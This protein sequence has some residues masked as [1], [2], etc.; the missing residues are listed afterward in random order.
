MSIQTV[1]GTITTSE[2]GI[3]LPHEHLFIDLRNQFTPFNDEWKNALSKQLVAIDNLGRL[4]L[5]PYALQD[6]LVLDDMEAA[7]NE[8]LLFKKAGGTTI[9]DCTSIGIKRQPQKLRDLSEQTG[10]YIIAGSGYYTEDTHPP[11]MAGWSAEEIAEQIIK[12]A[13]K[14][15]T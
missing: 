15:Q 8:A 14:V 1:T 5:N 4:R 12:Q 6:N 2:M 10:I 11:E 9:V 7:V 3:T 13:R